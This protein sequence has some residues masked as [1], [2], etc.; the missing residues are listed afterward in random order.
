MRLAL[1]EID[2]TI[3]HNAG[4]L[5]QKRLAQG[6]RLNIPEA[7]SL[8][9]FQMLQFI[10]S[11]KYSVAQLM[12]VGRQLLGR[13]QVLPGVADILGEVQIEG[14]FLD[15]KLLVLHVYIKPLDHRLLIILSKLFNI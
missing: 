6:I 9:V 10:R 4:S 7:T 2:K 5:A 14:T 13:K 3:L 11:G 12:D 8:L 1:H 15:G